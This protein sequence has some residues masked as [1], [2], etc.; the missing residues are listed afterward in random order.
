MDRRSE[1]IA[2]LLE[3]ALSERFA[4]P[5]TEVIQAIPIPV[6]IVHAGDLRLLTLNEL[7]AALLNHPG[8]RPIR[9]AHA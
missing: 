4:T 9:S 3:T 7:M 6:A 8:P 5:V 2:Q 1:A